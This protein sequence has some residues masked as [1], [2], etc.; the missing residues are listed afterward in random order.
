MASCLLPCTPI[1]P[2]K[3]PTQKGKNLPFLPFRVYIFSEGHQRLDNVAAPE[4]LSVPL[5]KYTS[6][7]MEHTG[8]GK[9]EYAI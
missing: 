9:T 8:L 1:P 3:E 5:R 6:L 7:S 2:E 4:S